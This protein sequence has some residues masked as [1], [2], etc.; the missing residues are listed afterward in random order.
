MSPAARLSQAS[1]VVVGARVSKSGQAL[2]QPGDL[3][4]LSASVKPGANGL[5]IVISEEVR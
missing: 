1:A 2:P 4:G 5:K 3:Q